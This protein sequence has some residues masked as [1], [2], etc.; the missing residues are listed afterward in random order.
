MPSDQDVIFRFNAVVKG[1][2]NYYSGSTQQSVLRKFYFV[3]R[4][5]AALTLAHR[6]KKKSTWWAFKKFGK[7]LT[8][9]YKNKK[10]KELSVKFEIPSVSNVSWNLN[11][12]KD[13]NTRDVLPV[14]QGVPVPRSL[15]IACSVFEFSCAVPNCP[16]QAKYWHYVKH[17]KKIKGKDHLKR[18]LALTAKQIPVCAPHHYLIHSGKYDG[19]SLRKMKGYSLS[20]FD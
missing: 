1:I 20:D 4:K 6:H 13:S 18:I 17:Q 10:N 14:I 11:S 19:P 16:N 3:L 15:S 7:D 12:G 8:I 9:V 2:K 5:S